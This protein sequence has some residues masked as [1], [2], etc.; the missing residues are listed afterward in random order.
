VIEASCPIAAHLDVMLLFR[1]R[2]Q[3]AMADAA[4]APF[5]GIVKQC[6]MTT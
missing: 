2:Q 5:L 4:S 6:G 1:A 3:V